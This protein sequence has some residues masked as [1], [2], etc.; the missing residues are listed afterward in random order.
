MLSIGIAASSVPAGLRELLWEPAHLYPDGVAGSVRIRGGPPVSPGYETDGDTNWR[1]RSARIWLP[2]CVFRCVTPWPSTSG[3]GRRTRRRWPRSRALFTAAPRVLT[4]EQAGGGHNLS[5]GHIAAAY[6]RNVLAF[7]E[8]CAVGRK[9]ATSAT[10]IST[11][12]AS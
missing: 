4:N 10:T 7:A 1:T 9:T 5:L 6:H 11:M 12:E 3:C 2:A 8:E